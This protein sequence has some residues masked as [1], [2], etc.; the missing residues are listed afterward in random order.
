MV[1]RIFYF[2][3]GGPE[4]PPFFHIH[5]FLYQIKN[6]RKNI[7]PIKPFLDYEEQSKNFIVR[8]GMIVVDHELDTL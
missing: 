8:K 2:W 3:D 4:C 1:K 6:D 7:K 5:R